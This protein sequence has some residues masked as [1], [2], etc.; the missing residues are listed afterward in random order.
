MPT[1]VEAS[2][3]L[4][5]SVRQDVATEKQYL[6]HF[7]ASQQKTFKAM[8]ETEIEDPSTGIPSVYRSNW[9]FQF[10]ADDDGH[11]AESDI[12]IRLNQLLSAVGSPG[13]SFQTS[14]DHRETRYKYENGVRYCYH[15]YSIERRIGSSAALWQVKYSP[16]TYSVIVPVQISFSWGTAIPVLS[17]APTEQART[18]KP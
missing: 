16:G 2:V 15:V 18:F 1:Q 11:I 6:S 5:F 7:D 10:P 8:F 12:Q 4:G 3:Q 14:S 9:S 17:G 13:A